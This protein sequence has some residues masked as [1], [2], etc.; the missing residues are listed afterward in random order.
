MADQEVRCGAECN[1]PLIAPSSAIVHLEWKRV[2]AAAK[3]VV[4]GD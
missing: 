1:T 2:K 3:M 4:V